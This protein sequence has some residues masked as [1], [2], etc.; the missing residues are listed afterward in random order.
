MIFLYILA[1]LVT[2][3]FVFFLVISKYK[4]KVFLENL[5]TFWH[6]VQVFRFM[7]RTVMRIL[8][9]AIVHDFSKFSDEEAPHFAKANGLG[10]LT[11]GSPEYNKMINKTLK[12]ALEHHYE[13]NSH[14]P[15]HHKGGVNEMGL[16]DQIEMLCD[17][18]AATLR[19]KNGSIKESI[20]L[21]AGRF[22]YNEDTK[23]KY[24]EFLKDINVY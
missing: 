13:N 18:K 3:F 15:E 2:A 16:L 21:N 1:T 10:S 23:K 14:H 19:T 5:R 17:W 20:E 4:I 8:K 24:I 11:Y 9:R 22:G 6:K 12:P 7:L